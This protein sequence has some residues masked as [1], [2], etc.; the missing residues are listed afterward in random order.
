[1]MR[2]STVIT[3][4]TA[5]F[6]VSTEASCRKMITPTNVK[7]P[8]WVDPCLK[9]TTDKVPA[10][11]Q[12]SSPQRFVNYMNKKIRCGNADWAMINLNGY[13][14]YMQ[15]SDISG[16]V[17]SSLVT[18]IGKDIVDV[19]K[20]YIGVPYLWGG[21]DKRGIDCSGLFYAVM[22]DMNVFDNDKTA[23]GYY[24]M[25]QNYP[26]TTTK[27]GDVVFFYKNGD[28]KHM[29]ILTDGMGGM[30]HASSGSGKV[31]TVTNYK[32]YYSSGYWEKVVTCKTDSLIAQ[33]RL[34]RVG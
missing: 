10:Y 4:F 2:C 30:I 21:N 6:V 32:T 8:I 27:A 11:I 3:L 5:L 17:G 9:T 15:L 19:A 18:C 16:F 31:T 12:N 1:M 7:V 26:V 20:T 29:G 23:A 34:V 28:W 24:N 13:A 33:R 14:V 22:K 25:L